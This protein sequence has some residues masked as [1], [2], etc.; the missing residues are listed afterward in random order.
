MRSA[1]RR[2]MCGKSLSARTPSDPVQNVI[3]L[4]NSGDASI[5]KAKSVSVLTTRGK[6]NKG[7]GGS[8][9]WMHKLIPN[10]CA[11]GAIARIK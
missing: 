9:G 3:P 5:N 1:K 7:K 6:L 4:A 2:I 10:S 11:K 8:S